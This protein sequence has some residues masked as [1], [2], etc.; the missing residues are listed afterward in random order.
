MIVSE[1]EVDA[2]LEFLGDS[3][4]AAKLRYDAAITAIQAREAYA[5]AYLSINERMSVEEKKMR[6]E[7]D[8]GTMRAARAATDAEAEFYGF[9]TMLDKAK[10]VLDT[11]RTEGANA[12]GME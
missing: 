6:A 9:K 10:A 11:W 8:P 5:R 2:A 1:K 3:E 12:R 4:R 7:V